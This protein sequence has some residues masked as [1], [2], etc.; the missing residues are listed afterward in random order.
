MRGACDDDRDADGATLAVRRMC[1]L[2]GCNCGKTSCT[3]EERGRIFWGVA[4]L[5]YVFLIA[6][7]PRGTGRTASATVGSDTTETLLHTYIACPT[8]TPT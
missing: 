5:F 1:V 6:G 3:R 8:A 4:G 2:G 7:V